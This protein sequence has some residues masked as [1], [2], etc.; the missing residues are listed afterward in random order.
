MVKK[1]V[2]DPFT[3]NVVNIEELHI[4][5]ETLEQ[6]LL[7]IHQPMLVVLA[8][9][10][11]EVVTV[12]DKCVEMKLP[13]HL[14]TDDTE[15]VEGINIYTNSFA[16]GFYIVDENL[17]VYTAAEIF[18]YHH[19]KGRYENKF[20]NAE[21][22]HVMMNFNQVIMLS[23]PNTVLDNTSV[24]KIR[25]IQKVKRDFLKIIYR[26]NTELLVPLEQ[27]RLVRKFVS[28]EGVVPKLNK[29]GSGDWEKQ[30]NVFKANVEDIAERL[31]TLYA[32]REQHIGFAFSKDNE[33]TK[34]FENSFSFDLT[35]D[36]EKAVAEIK[37][38]ME[39]NKPMDRLSLWRMLVLVRQKYQS[40]TSFKAVCDNKQV[41]CICPT[42]I[43]A[44]QHFHTFQKRYQEF[45]VTVKVLNR[46]VSPAEQKTSTKGIRRR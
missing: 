17:K 41:A 5:N 34:K 6:K 2:E 18:A 37:K 26:G 20:R 45:P 13:Y 14:L 28:R 29:L 44:E 30:N 10:E 16:Q 27:F 15:P 46:F 21:V 43:L 9:S 39:S 12:I 11:K 32:N 7:L 38:D 31:L 1:V 33:M 8:L 19:H 3:E 40:A 35:P 4:P 24:L 25:E 42:T 36:Q 22:I 23:M